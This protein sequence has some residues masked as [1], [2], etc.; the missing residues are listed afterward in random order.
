MKQLDIMKT[1][2]DNRIS[3][4]W[5]PKVVWATS[6]APIANQSKCE[7]VKFTETNGDLDAALE[8]AV[9]RLTGLVPAKPKLNKV[10]EEKV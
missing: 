10:I 8:L 6:K 2:I 4:D 1:L 3:I 5:A 9:K 7:G